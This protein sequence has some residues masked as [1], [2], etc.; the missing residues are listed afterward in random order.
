MKKLGFL[1]LVL[2]T[3]CGDYEL[4]NTCTELVE[5][6]T[7]VSYETYEI[8]FENNDV[9]EVIVTY[10]YTDSDYS[11]ISSIKQ[12]VNTE[13]EILISNRQIISDMDT[14]FKYQYILNDDS[15][16]ELK[17]QFNYTDDRINYVKYLE[18]R[19]FRCE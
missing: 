4:V 2:I 19:G 12:A 7:L 17:K 1:C 5:A 18:E 13:D 10:D 3:G 9:Y 8:K 16:D 14:Q 6:N 11:V 15:E